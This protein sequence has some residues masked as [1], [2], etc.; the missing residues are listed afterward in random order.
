[1]VLSF[2]GDGI[3]M[4][5]NGQE[6]G[7]PRRLEFFERDPIA[8]CTHP[9]GALYADLI[10]LKKKTSALW[11]GEWGAMMVHVPNDRLAQ[12]LSFVHQDAN[13]KVFAVFNLSPTAQKV[14]FEQTLFQ[15]SYT[16]HFSRKSATLD[17]STALELKPWEYRV[18]VR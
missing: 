12:V 3:P 9:N 11:N 17:A 5:Y 13:G 18:F 6:A 15:G 14:R 16:G 7:N 10:A 8:W 2:V 4:I 1:M